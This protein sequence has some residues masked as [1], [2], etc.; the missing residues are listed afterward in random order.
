[1]IPE[2][3]RTYVLELLMAL[4]PAAENFVIAGAQAIKFMLKEARG[5]KDIDFV[6]DVARLR[7]KEPS[8][9]NV[10]GQLGYKVVEGSNN[11]QFEKPIPNSKEV[12]RVEFMAPEEFKRDK[13]FRVDVEEGIHARFCTGGS[14]AIAE[15]SLH[16]LSG[17]LPDG[18]AFAADVRVTK[19]RALLMLKLLALDD[20]YRNIRGP[21]QQKHDRE[22]ART[23]SADCIAVISGQTDLT[24]FKEDLEKQFQRD[25]ALGMRV[26]E[27]LNWYFRENTSPGLLVYEESIVADQPLERAA[28]QRVTAEI[29]R[30]HR[31]MLQIVPPA[32][33]FQLAAAIEASTNVDRNR[34]LVEDFLGNLKQTATKITDA[35]AI[36]RLP[37]EGFGG[38]YRKGDK[39]TASASEALKGLSAMEVSLLAAHLQ[40]YAERLRPN[41]ELLERFG[42]VLS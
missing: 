18:T 26:L 37:G 15:S 38:A 6:L 36:E 42:F 12:L 11:F 2:P 31:M 3:Q 4:G 9:R 24:Q 30:A 29:D 41:P 34:P 39:F 23:H 19:P 21:A 17:K 20:R 8:V 14:I 35:R 28:R 33:F 25:P 5:T 10:L 22:E 32:E 7:E 16:R 13:D 1:M 27:I 40:T